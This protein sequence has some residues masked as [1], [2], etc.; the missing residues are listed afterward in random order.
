MLITK[1]L[2]S[3]FLQ[4]KQIAIGRVKTM[5]K[6]ANE[7]LKEDEIYD[8]AFYAKFTTSQ[9]IKNSTII[10]PI[11]E[12]Y[13]NIKSV[14]DVGCGVGAWSKFF[15]DKQAI[16]KGYDFDWVPEKFMSVPKKE[17]FV[18]C[19]LNERLNVKEKFDLVINIEVAEHLKPD[20]AKTF[21][22]DLT[23]LGD[24]I[25]FSAAIPY[26][27]GDGHLNEQFPEYWAQ[28]FDQHG[29]KP[30]D[31]IRPQIW[32]NKDIAQTWV[33]Q[34]MLLFVKKDLVELFPEKYRANKNALTK[35]FFLRFLKIR[36]LLNID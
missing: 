11:I 4:S 32:K 12:H 29:Y 22:A 1:Y 34:N 13:V 15:Y 6:P 5:Y 3:K 23:R 24:T 20:R 27:G 25:L 31:I 2:Y 30:I 33:K 19:D 28:L 10:F 7:I 14:I 8:D 35:L 21:V 16:V 18:A 17:Y 36:K 9:K 26:Q